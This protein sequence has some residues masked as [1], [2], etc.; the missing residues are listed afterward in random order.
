MSNLGKALKLLST[1]I[2]QQKWIFSYEEDPEDEPLMDTLDADEEDQTFHEAQTSVYV[3]APEAV[4]E[5]AETSPAP[6]A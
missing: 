3:T 5:P 2:T 4:A 1:L 6:P